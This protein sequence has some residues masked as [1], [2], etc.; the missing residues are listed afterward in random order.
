M[1]DVEGG[2]RAALRA[3]GLPGVGSRVFVD[4]EGSPQ[5]PYVTIGLVDSVDDESDAPL[6]LE[7]VQLDA[8]GAT[9]LQ[10]HEVYRSLRTWLRTLPPGSTL[11]PG[12]TFK[13]ARVVPGTSYLPD[14]DGTARYVITAEI[15]V[16]PT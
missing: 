14:D 16:A 9:K 5:L 7:L 13:G 11:A 3:E 10:A 15:I 1:T 2:L 8:W 6:D 12:T 4:V